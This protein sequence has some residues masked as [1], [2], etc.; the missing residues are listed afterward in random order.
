M[1]DGAAAKAFID[2]ITPSDSPMTRDDWVA[3]ERNQRLSTPDAAAGDPAPD[4]DLPVYDFSTGERVESEERF[5][6]QSVAA[7]TPVA[8]VFGSYT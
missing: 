4:F 1:S 5:H 8:L 6:L 7:N 2:S 3:S